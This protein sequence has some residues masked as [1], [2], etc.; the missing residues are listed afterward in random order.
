MNQNTDAPLLNIKKE[1]FDPISENTSDFVFQS[2]AI[3]KKEKLS[4]TDFNNFSGLE[5]KLNL[6]FGL[7]NIYTNFITT[8]FEA[9]KNSI[10][11][12]L[13]GNKTIQKIYWLNKNRKGV[14]FIETSILLSQLKYNLEIIKQSDNSFYQ[15]QNTDFQTIANINYLLN[16]TSQTVLDS[17]LLKDQLEFSNE[18]YSFITD[19]SQNAIATEY[20][21]SKFSDYSFRITISS[22][23]GTITIKDALFKK[24]TILLFPDFIPELQTPQF[25]RRLE[26]FLAVS[27]PTNIKCECL[28]V[29]FQELESFT[30]NYYSL[31]E[32]LR[33]KNTLDA[34]HNEKEISSNPEQYAVNLINS[35]TS[36]LETKNGRNK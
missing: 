34:H 35:L 4:K 17:Q 25:E 24:N 16:T 30:S 27:L 11:D 32:S 18:K 29:N 28:F 9:S 1:L 2:N 20:T 21:K 7:K 5:L 8:Q 6:L 19:N 3:N 10:E 33:F 13:N 14:F 15:I 31:H 23:N 36:I 22:G 12:Q 26:Q